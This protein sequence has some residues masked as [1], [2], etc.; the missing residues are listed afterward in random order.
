SSNELGSLLAHKGIEVR[1][2]QAL[3]SVNSAQRVATMVDGEEAS[4][5]MLIT[6][7]PSQTAPALIDT[8][9][10]DAT[11]RIPSDPI[12]LETARENVFVAG[13]ATYLTLPDGRELPHAPGVAARQA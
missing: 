11:G 4:F 10:V 13:D 5:Q 9:M 3:K 7:P 2:G 1:V 6:E 8:G 12:T